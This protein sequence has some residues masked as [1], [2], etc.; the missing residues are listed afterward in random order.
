MTLA[1]L[2]RTQTGQM[3]GVR[4][5]SKSHWQVNGWWEV[6]WKAPS[7]RWSPEVLSRDVISSASRGWEEQVRVGVRES[8]WN[9]AHQLQ[10][11]WSAVT[12]GL[13]LMTALTLSHL[14][15]Q[16]RRSR[17]LA[18][19]TPLFQHFHCRFHAHSWTFMV[20]AQAGVDRR[21]FWSSIHTVLPFFLTQAAQPELQCTSALDLTGKQGFCKKKGKYI[22][23]PRHSQGPCCCQK[24]TYSFLFPFWKRIM[25]MNITFYF[26]GRGLRWVQTL[27]EAN[28]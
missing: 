12:V 5:E 14:S 11:L 15:Q 2:K 16:H 27:R 8:D 20:H 13:R 9:G 7:V 21:A 25:W 28:V 6:Q 18:L 24:I 17:L 10:L 26:C 22:C 23:L 19:Q 3:L 4:H 1:G